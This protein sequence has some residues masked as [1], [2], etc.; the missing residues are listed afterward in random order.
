VEK[1]MLA[2]LL[3]SVLALCIGDPV[4]PNI[5]ETF[6]SRGSLSVQINGGPTIYGQ[7]YWAVNQPNGLG[8]ESYMFHQFPQMD[9]YL[10]Q[11]YDLR[12]SFDMGGPNRTECERHQLDGRMPRVWDWVSHATY[13]GQENIKNKKL[14]IWEFR[15]GYGLLQLGVTEQMPDI[16][17]WTSRNSHNRVFIVDIDQF[18]AAP[19]KDRIFDVPKQCHDRVPTKKRSQGKRCVSRSTAIARAKV[20]VDN[21]VPYDQQGH[22][23][24]YR[25]DCSGYVSMAWQLSKPGLTTSTLPSVAHRISKEELQSGDVLLDVQEHVVI[26]AGWADSSQSQYHAMEETRPGEGT[27]AR[28]TPYPYWYNKSAFVPYRFNQIC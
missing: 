26:F 16:P 2:L 7:A 23:D 18:D 6:E 13:K 5:S 9:I 3:L 14:N 20:W 12:A 28:V 21:H 1:E 17:V 4:R 24:G 27:V 25:E 15:T 10:L 11:R 19:P 22:Y 8:L